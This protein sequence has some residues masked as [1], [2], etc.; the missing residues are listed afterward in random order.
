MKPVI[1]FIV[2][3]HNHT[4]HLPKLFD[5]IMRQGVE[6]V[7]VVLV[8]DCPEESSESVAEAYNSKGL[9]VTHIALTE[10]HYQSTRFVG[11]AAAKA[12]II[13]FADADDILFGDNSLTSHLELFSEKKPDILHFRAAWVN[14]GVYKRTLPQMD[15]IAPELQGQDIFCQHVA[16]CKAHSLWCRFISRDL[17]LRTQPL[18]NKAT[19]VKRAGDVYLTTLLTSHAN[20]YVGS[21]ITGYGYSFFPGKFDVVNPEIA[22]SL[23]VGLQELTPV[24]HALK[25]NA[26]TIHKFTNNILDKLTVNMGRY[27]RDVVKE[28]GYKISQKSINRLQ[29]V[30][31]LEDI[32]RLLLISNGINAT[33]LTTIHYNISKTSF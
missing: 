15:P 7:E 13:G 29:K 10:R 26:D 14:D 33:K 4:A 20:R 6:G 21:D 8:D 32:I 22:Y 11:M 28:H 9:C 18:L 27:C 1:S 12:D 3:N 17:F 5:S 19:A 30:A 24:L 23:Y 31:S 16:Q 25:F 2:P